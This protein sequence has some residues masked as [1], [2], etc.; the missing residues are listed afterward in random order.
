MRSIFSLAF[1]T[2]SGAPLSLSCVPRERILSRGNFFLRMSNLP[3][4]TPKNS[5]GFTVSRLIIVSVNSLQ[6]KFH[7]ADNAG[8]SLSVFTISNLQILRSVFKVN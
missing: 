4:F 1:S 7:N 6:F 3:L 2:C 8:R 5:I